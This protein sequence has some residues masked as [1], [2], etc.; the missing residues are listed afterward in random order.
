M[1]VNVFFL[2]CVPCSVFIFSLFAPVG[3]KESVHYFDSYNPKH[4]LNCIPVPMES[5]LMWIMTQIP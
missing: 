3:E 1:P 2:F 4:N 5:H